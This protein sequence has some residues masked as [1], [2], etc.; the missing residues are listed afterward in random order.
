[1]QRTH[2]LQRLGKCVKC[3]GAL[4]GRCIWIFI[5]KKVSCSRTKFVHSTEFIADEIVK[6][7]HNGGLGGHFGIDK[8]TV[9][10]KERYFWPSINKDVKIFVE[11]CR[12]FQLAKGKSQN[13]GLYTPI[14][15]P[16]RPW[17][18]ISMD[19]ILGLPRM[20]SGHDYVMV[21][22]DKFLN[23]AHFI[24][25]KKTN[26]ATKV[27]VLFFKEIVWLHGL[28]RSITLIGI[29]D[30][31]DIFGGHF[32][33]IWVPSCCTIQHIIHKQMD[34]PRWLTRVLGIC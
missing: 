12:I 4:I 27:V 7:L 5:F 29:Q 11:C 14:L 21:V 31:L 15:V 18:D 3:L 8:T 17:E 6:E 28:P 1:M 30:F 25:C 10:V 22:V 33:R 9:L 19:F 23:M 16:K 24:P 13:I 34:R 26:D 2:I 20:Q 32:G